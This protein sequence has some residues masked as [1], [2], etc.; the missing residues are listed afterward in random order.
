MDYTEH[1]SHMPNLILCTALRRRPSEIILRTGMI[2]C[3]R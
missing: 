3:D 2:P 1:T